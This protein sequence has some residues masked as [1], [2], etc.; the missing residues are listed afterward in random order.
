MQPGTE[1]LGTRLT[2]TLPADEILQ[3]IGDSVI[4]PVLSDGARTDTLSDAFAALAASLR[5]VDLA[6]APDRLDLTLDLGD[7]IDALPSPFDITL[8]T[9]VGGVDGGRR[10]GID[11]GGV[12][13][14]ISRRG[15][16]AVPLA[17][18]SFRGCMLQARFD[19]ALQ[20]AMQT[21][22]SCAR[23]RV[24]QAGFGCGLPDASV[25]CPHPSHASPICCKYT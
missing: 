18:M 11:E 19:V 24:P 1:G 4:D 16:E 12:D 8:D 20:F 10:R 25:L 2:A 13:R 6:F 14:A 9:A 3:R 23:R 7:F 22:S 15:V 21:G 5:T 17:A